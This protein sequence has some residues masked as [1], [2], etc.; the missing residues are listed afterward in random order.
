MK[1]FTATDK[2]ALDAFR[3]LSEKEGILPALE[4]AHALAYLR[5]NNNEIEPG[6]D[7]VV[8]LSGRGDKDVHTVAEALGINL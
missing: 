1:Y 5:Q 8:C 2:E 7:V 3:W 6:E 4:S